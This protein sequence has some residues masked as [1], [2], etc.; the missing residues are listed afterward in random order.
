MS[1]ELLVEKILGVG[2]NKFTVGDFVVSIKG[3]WAYK[4]IGEVIGVTENGIEVLWT[5]KN[6]STENPKNLKPFNKEVPKFELGETIKERD[7]GKV[8]IV[9]SLKSPNKVEVKW[10]TGKYEVVGVDIIYI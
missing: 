6:Y 5:F 3:Q 1:I 2:G 8:G 9:W 4:N 7:T 10:N